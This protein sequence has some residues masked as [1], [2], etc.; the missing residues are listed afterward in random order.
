MCNNYLLAHPQQHNSLLTNTYSANGVISSQAAKFILAGPWSLDVKGG[1]VTLFVANI[2][3][4]LPDGARLHYH[5][6]SNFHQ[7]HG[8]SSQ[9]NANNNG[10]IHGTMDVGLKSGLK[11]LQ[12]D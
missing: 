12:F 7:L 3:A 2:M 1:I 6:F 9:L 8:S 5:T 4:V 11:Y 10:L